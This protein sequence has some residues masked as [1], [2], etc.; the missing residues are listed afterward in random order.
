MLNKDFYDKREDITGMFNMK[1]ECNEEDI[2]SITEALEQICIVIYPVSGIQDVP[3]KFKKIIQINC[4]IK[5]NIMQLNPCAKGST[6]EINVQLICYKENFKN[7]KNALSKIFYVE[8]GIQNKSNKKMFYLS[9][10]F[11]KH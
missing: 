8:K 3:Y 7:V 4:K 6:N 5:E 11:K 1:I 2:Q 9:L 10:R